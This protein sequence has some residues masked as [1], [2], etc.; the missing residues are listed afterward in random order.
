MSIEPVTRGKMAQVLLI[1][2]AALAVG[3]V[4]IAIGIWIFIFGS[5]LYVRD[6][7]G[8]EDILSKA[9]KLK[10]MLFLGKISY[11]LYLLHMIPLYGVMYG[12]NA[13]DLPQATY[14][15]LLGFGTFALAIPF[16][17]F[18]T[19]YVE[20]AFYRSERRAPVAVENTL[21]ARSGLREVT[22]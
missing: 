17:L 14:I 2:A 11:S 22:R 21:P 9:L 20:G 8:S 18:A 5:A 15:A 3:A 10:P 7:A 12:L 6:R 4:S 19:R 16:S 1:S 13:L